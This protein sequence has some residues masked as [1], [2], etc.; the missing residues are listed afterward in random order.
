MIHIVEGGFY[1]HRLLT[2]YTIVQSASHEAVQETARAFGASKFLAMVSA[3][4]EYA[5]RMI[6]GGCVSL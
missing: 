6:V 5:E 3:R 4:V 1:A 2:S